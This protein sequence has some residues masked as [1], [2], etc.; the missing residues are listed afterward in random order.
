MNMLLDIV[1]NEALVKSIRAIQWIS[2]GNN[3]LVFNIDHV[4]R[5]STFWMTYRDWPYIW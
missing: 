5:L 2:I 4:P 1:L 3:E